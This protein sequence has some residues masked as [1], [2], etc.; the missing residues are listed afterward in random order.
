MRRKAS[1]MRQKASNMLQ[2]ASNMRQKASKLRPKAS[3]MRQK[4]S[5]MR[6]KASNMRQKA[7]KM[8]HPQSW[9]L[10][11][12]LVPNCERGLDIV[13]PE[14]ARY[15]TESIQRNIQ[16]PSGMRFHGGASVN[17]GGFDTHFLSIWNAMTTACFCLYLCGMRAL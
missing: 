7:S 14:L 13:Y 11:L 4:A 5:N 12:S 3:K 8:R 2:K 6:Q 9:Q 16:T 1:Q 17:P 15:Y 10:I